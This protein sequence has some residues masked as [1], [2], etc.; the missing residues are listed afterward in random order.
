MNRRSARS[1]GRGAL[2]PGS[3]SSPAS[4]F[5]LMTSRPTI[6]TGRSAPRR[7]ARDRSCAPCRRSPTR[8]P[9]QSASRS[10]RCRSRRRACCGR[11]GGA[12]ARP[13]AGNS[14]PPICA[15]SQARRALP[16]LPRDCQ[17]WSHGTPRSSRHG[18]SAA[19]PGAGGARRAPPAGVDAH[20]DADISRGATGCCISWWPL[21][22]IAGYPPR[23]YTGAN[24]GFEVPI[25]PCRSAP[26]S[27]G[28]PDR[29]RWPVRLSSLR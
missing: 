24:S 17:L 29:T 18:A 4:Y 10:A 5:G 3:A 1:A 13:R 12:G 14:F 19:G 22:R 23:S 11:W 2:T 26:Q 28:R 15:D 16:C 7:S 20:P 25:H 6:P 8:W 27:P 21:S 9:M